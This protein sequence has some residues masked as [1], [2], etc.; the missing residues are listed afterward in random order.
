[1]NDELTDYEAAYL[2]WLV[3][4][5]RE[6]GEPRADKRPPG[7]TLDAIEHKLRVLTGDPGIKTKEGSLMPHVQMTRR[8]V[9][10]EY[11]VDGRLVRYFGSGA[12]YPSVTWQCLCGTGGYCDHI[13]AAMNC[14]E[15]LATAEPVQI[16]LGQAA[17]N[18]EHTEW[19]VATRPRP[20]ASTI[21]GVWTDDEVLVAEAPY[22]P[23]AI[24]QKRTVTDWEEAAAPAHPT[25][26]SPDRTEAGDA[27][28]GPSVP[29]QSTS[30]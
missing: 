13:R 4:D 10:E 8:R 25:P 1:M 9:E 14:Q 17:D 16:T 20:D 2:L 3:N 6:A 24:V 21:Y 18:G 5:A 12:S 15:A 27:H 22:M 26:L 7:V 19:R 29:G 30:S 23:G 28:D 11:D